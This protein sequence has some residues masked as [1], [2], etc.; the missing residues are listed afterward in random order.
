MPRS[1]RL[2]YSLVDVWKFQVLYLDDDLLILKS[3]KGIVHVMVRNNAV[4]T[5]AADTPPAPI[6]SAAGDVGLP[7]VNEMSGELSSTDGFLAQTSN[8]KKRK[9]ED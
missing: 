5:K 1:S 3:C 9:W 4:D 6:S 2:A 8:A 7:N